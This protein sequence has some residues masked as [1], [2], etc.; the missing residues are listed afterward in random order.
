MPHEMSAVER[1]QFLLA[2]GRTGHV[3]TVR[4][5][6]RAH[7]APV[8]FTLDG[9]DVLFN[10]S[11]DTVKGRNLQRTGRASFSVD[12]PVMP[13]AFVHLE[14]PVTI[15]D[16]PE[17]YRP[18]ARRISS[19]YVPFDEVDAFTDRNAVPGELM[20]RLSPETIVAIADMAGWD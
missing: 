4:A 20:V 11:A 17:A 3:A 1:R 5:D 18:W 14:G 19:R 15:E 9:D 13:Y 16:D 12:L 7:V 6:G 10:T 8:W 2:P